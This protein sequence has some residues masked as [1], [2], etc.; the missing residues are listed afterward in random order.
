MRTVR[1]P[2]P[3]EVQLHRVSL[4]DDPR[5]IATG[6][7][8]LSHEEH[9]RAE[10]FRTAQDHRRYVLT[11]ARLREIVGR[12]LDLSPEAVPIVHDAQGKPGVD[13]AMHDGVHFNCSHSGELGVIALA[14]APVGIDIEQLRPLGDVLEL[15][16]AQFS[17]DERAVIRRARSDERTA[18]FLHCWTSKEAVLK[19]T[20]VGIANGMEHFSVALDRERQHLCL[21]DLARLDRPTTLETRAAHAALLTLARIAPEPGYV[22]AVAVAAVEISLCWKT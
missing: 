17:I 8:Q 3:I 10:R 22:G 9:A 14:G 6:L 19:A 11:R 2:A 21:P 4:R 18:L 5:A 7:R 12:H 1:T 15:A 20:G 16:D 13:A